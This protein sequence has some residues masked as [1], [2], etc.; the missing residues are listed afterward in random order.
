M[1]AKAI[2]CG[3]SV[4]R[5]AKLPLWYWLL[6]RREPGLGEMRVTRC[7]SQGMLEVAGKWKKIGEMAGFKMEGIPAQPLEPVVGVVSLLEKGA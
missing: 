4:E 1:L 7:L 3:R 5:L 2:T 6:T